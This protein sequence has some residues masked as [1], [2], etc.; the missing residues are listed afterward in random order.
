MTTTI[1]YPMARKLAEDWVADDPAAQCT[2]LQCGKKFAVAGM[3]GPSVTCPFCNFRPGEG[4]CK[5]AI[6]GMKDRK[7]AEPVAEPVEEKPVAAPPGLADVIGNESACTQIR[8]ALDAHRARLAAVDGK[9][10]A[11]AICFPHTIF[12]ASGG[13]GKSML[14]RIIAR[15]VNRPMRVC[16]GWSLQNPARVV[17]MLRSLKAGDILFIDEIQG[18]KPQCQDVLLLAMEDRIVMPIEKAGKPASTPVKLPA[19]T[20]IGSTTDE[21]RMANPLLQRFKYIIHLQRM[22]AADLARAIGERAA[23]QSWSVTADAARLIGQRAH[24]TPRLALRLLDACLDTAL[25]GG[26]N[27]VD[28][29][30]VESACEIG[31]IDNLGLNA[32][33]R[34]YLELLDAAGGGPV[35]PQH[36]RRADGQSNAVES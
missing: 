7:P 34:R 11:K 16:T 2:C 32:A 5:A 29:M 35:R 23:R 22:T 30:V 12:C 9:S 10:A 28:E 3:A 18:L 24:G 17:D 31:Q 36:H 1:D 15:E 25:A 14:S 13:T 26:D 27:T 33:E 6:D 8:I 19:F 21:F 20:L 4:A